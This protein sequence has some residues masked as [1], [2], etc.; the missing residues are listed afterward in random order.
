MREGAGVADRG[1]EMKHGIASRHRIADGAAVEHVPFDEADVE[2][3]EIG[4][5]AR[6]EV[7]EDGDFDT[8]VQQA[9]HHVAADEAAA[10]RDQCFLHDCGC[11]RRVT[12]H[13]AS[14]AAKPKTPSPDCM[15]LLCAGT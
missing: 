10:A 14:S 2:A 4:A 15:S 3:V 7:V 6:R 5:I 13:S 12:A 1:R 9:A 8:V 11:L